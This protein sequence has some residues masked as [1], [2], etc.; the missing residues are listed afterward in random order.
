MALGFE[1]PGGEWLD[2]QAKSEPGV[3]G[4]AERF[5][6]WLRLEIRR[7]LAPA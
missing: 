4:A 1:A 7:S 6:S 5:V 2:V 3:A